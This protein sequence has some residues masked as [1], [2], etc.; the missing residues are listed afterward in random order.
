MG[1]YS[2][3]NQIQDHFKPIYE[4]L[5]RKLPT[6]FSGFP[7]DAIQRPMM[8]VSEE[9]RQATFQALWDRGA[10]HFWRKSVIKHPRRQL[11]VRDSCKLSRPLH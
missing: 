8:Q 4:E 1:Q 3:S 7:I 5:F 11:T 9:E 2:L 10:F 6:T